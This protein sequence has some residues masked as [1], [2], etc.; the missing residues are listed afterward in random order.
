MFY[1]QKTECKVTDFFCFMVKNEKK[2]KRACRLF[3]RLND[4]NLDLKILFL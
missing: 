1:S 3:N 2:N 4:L